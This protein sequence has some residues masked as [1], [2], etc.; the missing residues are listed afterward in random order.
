MIQKTKAAHRR[1]PRTASP[2]RTRDAKVLDIP[3]PP[4]KEK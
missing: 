2:A 4:N 1:V 3:E